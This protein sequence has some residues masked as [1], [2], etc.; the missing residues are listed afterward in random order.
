MYSF[1]WQIY[2]KFTY[3]SAAVV[4][5]AV[6]ES[7]HYMLALNTGVLIPLVQYFKV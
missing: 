4:S 3:N 1:P 2:E 7:A 5:Q 6:R